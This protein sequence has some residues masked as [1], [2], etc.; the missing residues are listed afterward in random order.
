M[1]YLKKKN[2][3]ID[4]SKNNEEPKKLYYQMLDKSKIRVIEAKS[5]KE[6]ATLEEL[7]KELEKINESLKNSAILI[8]K[9]SNKE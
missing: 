9:L 6:S 3:S 5:E 7:Y 4:I 2:E 8:K 1:D